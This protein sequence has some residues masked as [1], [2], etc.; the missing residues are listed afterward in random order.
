MDLYKGS[1]TVL[2][3]TSPFALYS[4]ADASFDDASFSQSSMTGMVQAHGMSSL[5]YEKLKSD[6]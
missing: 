4:E 3:R 5:L 2:G 6:R 1:A